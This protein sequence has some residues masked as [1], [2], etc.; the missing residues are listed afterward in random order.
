MEPVDPPPDVHPAMLPPYCLS[1]TDLIEQGKSPTGALTDVSSITETNSINTWI[2]GKYPDMWGEKRRAIEVYLSLQG[3]RPRQPLHPLTCWQ[4]SSDTQDSSDLVELELE[5]DEDEEQQNL[6]SEENAHY[7]V[8]HWHHTAPIK[9]HH[10][11][12]TN[13]EDIVPDSEEEDNG[14]GSEDE[15]NTFPSAR[16]RMGQRQAKTDQE[17]LDRRELEVKLASADRDFRD[18]QLELA[19]A[20]VEYKEIDTKLYHE[21]FLSGGVLTGSQ[22]NTPNGDTMQAWYKAIKAINMATWKIAEGRKKRRDYLLA[23]QGEGWWPYFR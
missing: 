21:M 10:V 22:V 3:V 12:G 2:R 7:F 13:A 23:L 5:E 9:T 15:S 19:I 8:G 17:V 14:A 6:Y 1:L 20:R 16:G 4:R 18:G 11:D